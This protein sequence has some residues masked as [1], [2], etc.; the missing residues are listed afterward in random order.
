M[1]LTKH[2]TFLGLALAVTFGFVPAGTVKGD[3]VDE[4]IIA[5]MRERHIPGVSLAVISAGRIV[6]EQGYG[7]SDVAART[8]VTANTL[9]EAGSVSKPVAALAALHLVEQ[10]KL[11]LDEKVN[12]KLRS[13]HLPENHFTEDHPVTLRLILCHCAGITV[14]GF[15]PGYPVGAPLPSLVQ[16]LDGEAPAHSAPIRVDQV[17]G[18]EW[19]YSGGGYLVMQALV[20]DVTEKPFADY[21][22]DA[23]FKPLGMVASTFA[24]PLPKAWEVH[25]ATGYTG[26]P[27]HALTGRW[28]VQPALAAGG[29]WTTAGDLAR[30][31]IGMQRSLGGASNPIISQALARQMVTEQSG[32][33]GLGFMVGGTPSRFGH[34]GGETGF[35]AV[36]VAFPTGEGAVILMNAD[37]DVDA[38]AD[39]LV[40][41]I[42]QRYHWPGY[43]DPH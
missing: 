23:V 12:G 6:R 13:W 31:Y 11:S 20:T 36:T 3:H 40:R 15:S 2:G 19:R 38:V 37:T 26:E 10:D 29:L 28:E 41:A 1:I 14:H 16:I 5:Q 35:H 30:F 32:D 4:A 27:L 24:Q 9:F 43:A 25:A 17:P 42:G 39:V 18:S 22:E 34:N 7:Y 8:P 21:V 33:S